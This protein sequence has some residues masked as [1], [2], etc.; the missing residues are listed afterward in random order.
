MPTAHIAGSETEIE[1]VY[2]PV[3]ARREV[4]ASLI[5]A[6]CRTVILDWALIA[7]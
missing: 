6:L 3:H 1:A 4:V 5:V 2:A 7:A